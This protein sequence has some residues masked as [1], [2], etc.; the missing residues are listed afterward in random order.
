[1]TSMNCR[2]PLQLW[3]EGLLAVSGGTNSIG[4]ELFEDLGTCTQ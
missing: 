2:T 1:M 3:T 4:A